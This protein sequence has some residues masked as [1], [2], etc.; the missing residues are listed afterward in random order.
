MI[1]IFKREFKSYFI[2]MSGYVFI[3]VLWL[4][5]GIFATALNLIGQYAAYE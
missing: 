5:S 4:F 1:A 3:G 2:N